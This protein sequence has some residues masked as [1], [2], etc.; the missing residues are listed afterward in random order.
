MRINL[1]L[2]IRYKGSVPGM[3]RA[4]AACAPGK[5]SPIDWWLVLLSEAF[6]GSLDMC[7]NSPGVWVRVT[8][9]RVG[10]HVPTVVPPALSAQKAPCYV[11]CQR[12]TGGTTRPPA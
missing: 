2:E 1:G 4:G 11:A 6:S 12:G 5:H 10:L 7:P 3:R 9:S 8:T